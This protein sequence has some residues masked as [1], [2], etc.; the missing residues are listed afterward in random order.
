M[1]EPKELLKQNSRSSFQI[2]KTIFSTGLH[3]IFSTISISR[4][5]PVRIWQDSAPMLPAAEEDLEAGAA[6]GVAA[7][8]TISSWVTPEESSLPTHLV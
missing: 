6:D 5:S 2:T 7:E 4:I 1:I 8:I 3:T